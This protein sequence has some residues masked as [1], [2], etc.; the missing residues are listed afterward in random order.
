MIAILIIIIALQVYIF[1]TVIKK[2]GVFKNVFN[3]F[4]ELN[5]VKNI[6]YK[7][8]ANDVFKTIVNGINSYL[9]NNGSRANDYHLMQDI[10]ERNC[11]SAEE[12]IQSQVP[13]TL[14][15][16]LVGTMFGIIIGLGGLDLNQLFGD[17]LHTETITQLLSDVS[18]AMIASVF[19]IIFTTILTFFFKDAK[20]KNASNKNLF[21]SWIQANLLPNMSSDVNVALEK[22]S[23]A[24]SQFNEQFAENTQKLNET[25][26]L[27]SETS[28][29]QAELYKVINQLDISEMAKANVKV[30]KA[31]QNS[32]DEIT[33]LAQMLHSSQ[34]YVNEVRLLNENLDKSEQR[35]KMFEEMGDFFRTEINAIET[36]KQM[37]LNSIEESNE[38]FN[39]EFNKF[40]GKYEDKAD[41]VVEDL[42]NKFESQNAELTKL[43]AKQEDIIKG[44]DFSSMPSKMSK[45][46][47]IVNSL[48]HKIET[49][50]KNISKEIA[51]INVSVSLPDKNSTN[52]VNKDRISVIVGI[53][54]IIVLGIVSIM[55]G[56]VLSSGAM[57]TIGILTVLGC[58]SVLVSKRFL[59]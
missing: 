2:I 32:A 20:A 29:S 6:S 37:I 42:S 21:L 35:T 26:S 7:N 58:V 34:I 54:S 33:Y 40:V 45:L 30:Y 39:G 8:E 28:R 36:R 27:V 19:G 25:L 44:S 5:S 59:K 23:S 55:G 12:E 47:N 52:S 56:V 24:L 11:D 17:G 4:Y 48:S 57:T 46:E 18:K 10:V 38:K 49:T 16:G 1:A 14:Y 31:L 41:K 3:T 51:D 53:I 15:L 43:A 13:T 22:M 9:N 50:E